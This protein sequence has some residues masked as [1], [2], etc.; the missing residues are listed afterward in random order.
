MWGIQ[1]VTLPSLKCLGIS[2]LAITSKKRLSGFHGKLRQKCLSSILIVFGRQY[3]EK[4]MRRMRFGRNMCQL[5]ES[6]VSMKRITF[7]RWVKR[8]LAVLAL[9]FFTIA[10]KSMATR[11]NH[12][13]I[14]RAS[15]I[16]NSGISFSCSITALTVK[17]KS[18]QNPQSIQGRVLKELLA[19]KWASKLYLRPMSCAL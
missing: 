4:M 1:A 2:R 9:N 14:K 10:A 7:G 12:L 13:K 8:V 17:W 18:S 3:L 5:K 19:S 15:V 6:L 16:S 11:K